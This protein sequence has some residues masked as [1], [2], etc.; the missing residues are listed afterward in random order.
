MIEIMRSELDYYIAEM[1]AGRLRIVHGVTTPQI[2]TV[3]YKDGAFVKHRY[4][5]YTDE[6][7]E[8]V[9]GEDEVR[10]LIQYFGGA[11]L[12]GADVQRAAREQSTEGDP[13]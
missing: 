11:S 12:W 9:L 8:S 6:L 2:W 7:Y 3:E 10:R 1:K 5:E 4:D 13:E